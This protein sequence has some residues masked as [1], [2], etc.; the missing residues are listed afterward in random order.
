MYVHMYIYVYICMYLQ[1]GTKLRGGED[2]SLKPCLEP[3]HKFPILI[4]KAIS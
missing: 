4:L 1:Q 3:R 2:G